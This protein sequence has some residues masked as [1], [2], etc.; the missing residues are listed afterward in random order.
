MLQA[1]RAISAERREQLATLLANEITSDQLEVVEKKKLIELLGQLND[2]EPVILASYDGERTDD[3]YIERH[4]DV[5]VGPSTHAASTADEWDRAAL[6]GTY[7]R[8]LR[9]L[10]LLRARFSS[11][12]DVPRIDPATGDLKSSGDEQ[13]DLGVLLLRFVLDPPALPAA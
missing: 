1:S 12:N 6:H 4:R 11:A 10:G 8:T 13:S 7:R 2:V 3:D 9:Q 5:I